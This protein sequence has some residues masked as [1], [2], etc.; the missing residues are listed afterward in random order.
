VT[1]LAIVGGVGL[2]GLLVREQ[3]ADRVLGLLQGAGGALAAACG[4]HGGQLL[5]AGGAWRL[6]TRPAGAPSLPTFVA[7]RWLREGING[8]L[9]MLPIAGPLAGVRLLAR[10]GVAV[11]DAVAATVA[12]TSIELVSQAAFVLL[13]VWLLVLDR[14]TAAVSGWMI[15]G[16]S[17]LVM[18]ASLLLPAQLF[19]LGRLA[20]LLARRLEWARGMAG[21]HEA[22]RECWRDPWRVTLAIAAHLG[23]WLLGGAEVWLALHAFGNETGPLACLSIESLAG[24]IR[25]AAFMVPGALGVQE[26]GLVLICG[27]FGLPPATGLALSL[28]KRLREVAFGAPSLVLWLFLERHAAQSIGRRP[29]CP[30]APT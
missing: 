1:A 5:L 27:L 13:G 20:H 10:R 8:M 23:A 6:V 29:A 4:V 25:T 18:A 19:G 30:S 28:F 3:G 12:D 24:A 22:I 2:G 11:P 16:F 17:G 14:G 7:L 21:L 15:A 26:G 9:P